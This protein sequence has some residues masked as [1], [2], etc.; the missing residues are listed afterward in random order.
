MSS[1]DKEKIIK[2]GVPESSRINHE[3]D[4]HFRTVGDPKD[5]AHIAK[6]IREIYPHMRKLEE[7]GYNEYHDYEYIPIDEILAEIN[8]AISKQAKEEEPGFTIFVSVMGNNT[9]KAGKYTDCIVKLLITFMNT[10]TGAM[11]QTTSIGIGR[12][13]SEK[14][15]F[16]AITNAFKYAI[17]YTFMI[18]AGGGDP[19]NDSYIDEPQTKSDNKKDNNSNEESDSQSKKGSGKSKKDKKKSKKNKPDKK[20]ELNKIKEKF[21]KHKDIVQSECKKALN[22][23]GLEAKKLSELKKLSADRIREIN[24][25]IKER[26]NG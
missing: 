10:E 6:K 25:T 11:I 14:H 17:K 18:A 2:E 1:E 20:E 23:A 12:D 13:R 5:V 9:N 4:K 21:S 15:I 8:R 16:K 19:E 3:F 7:S 24:D 22:E 26:V